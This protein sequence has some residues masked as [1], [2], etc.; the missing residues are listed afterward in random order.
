MKPAPFA[1]Y[2]PGS[3]AE[4][5]ALL[6]DLPNAR[7]LAG[8][9]SLVPMLNFR[10]A[11]P[12]HLID[13]NSATGL[14]DIAV[15]DGILSI[16]A[17]ATQRAVER[18]QVVRRWCP[19]LTQAIHHVGHQQTRNRG[20]LGGSLCHMDPAAELPVA[21]AAIGPMLLVAGPGGERRMRFDE[22]STGYLGNALEPGEILVTVEFPVLPA[23]GRTAFVE[24]ARRPA[25][26]AI[27]AVAAQLVMTPAGLV[28]DVRLAVGGLAAAPVRLTQAEYALIGSGLDDSAIKQAARMAADQPADGDALN[29]AAYR[30]HL[31]GVL[32]ERALR[33]ILAGEDADA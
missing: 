2:I 3:L 17:M 21:A 9:Q 7:L 24:V 13:L 10:I 18:S 30:Q 15:Q 29:P 5:I 28:S 6:A 12:D 32:V 26:F 20:T 1:Y 4:A 8:G 33:R 11:T 16:G 14:R 19:L 31:A 22:F 23:G 25:D 27:V